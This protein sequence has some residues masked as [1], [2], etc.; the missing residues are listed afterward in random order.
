[1]KY[2][3]YLEKGKE[4]IGCEDT[5]MILTVTQHGLVIQITILVLLIVIVPE[6]LND[7]QVEVIVVFLVVITVQ[8]EVIQVAGVA[9]QNL[10]HDHLVGALFMIDASLHHHIDLIEE[11]HRDA[12]LEG[13]HIVVIVEV[14]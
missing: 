3:E 2:F 13:A 11:V 7:R 4:D 14:L 10:P 8:Q 9:V 12:V 5:A 6:E 1:M